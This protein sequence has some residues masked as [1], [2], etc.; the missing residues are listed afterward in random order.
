[1]HRLQAWDG[2]AQ[3]AACAF[4]GLPGLV[5]QRFTAGPGREGKK[6]GAGRPTYAVVRTGFLAAQLL[7]L[8][9]GVGGAKQKGTGSFSN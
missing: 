5:L 1:L 8:F 2:V 6:A 7:L 3:V 4:G 9:L